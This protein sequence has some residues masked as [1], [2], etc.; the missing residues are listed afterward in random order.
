[1][2]SPQ[3]ILTPGLHFRRTAKKKLDF[4]TCS[5][6]QSPD[7][8]RSRHSVS[9][10]LHSVNDYLVITMPGLSFRL[11]VCYGDRNTLSAVCIVAEG[12]HK[13]MIFAW[14]ERWRQA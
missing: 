6:P 13:L 5:C 3:A 8:A 10:P 2:N 12:H 9:A 7:S 14:V 1:M 11:K 4:F